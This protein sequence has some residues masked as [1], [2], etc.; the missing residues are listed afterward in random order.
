MHKF[1]V[2]EQREK[3]AGAIYH[4]LYPTMES[5]LAVASSKMMLQVVNRQVGE[6]QVTDELN[7]Q[8]FATLNSH[9]GRP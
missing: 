4:G 1:K 2:I 3:H 7:T 5:A 9:G 6:V 8:T